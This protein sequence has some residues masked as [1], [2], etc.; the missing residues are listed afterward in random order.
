MRS[1]RRMSDIGRLAGHESHHHY[2]RF[3]PYDKCAKLDV[4]N[5]SVSNM[6]KEK[7]ALSQEKNAHFENMGKDQNSRGQFSGDE[8]IMAAHALVDLS[9]AKS[10][11]G[12]DVAGSRL[13]KLN[14][15]A[16][17]SPFPQSNNSRNMASGGC[18]EVGSRSHVLKS[19]QLFEEQYM[20]LLQE[21]N[22]KGKKKRGANERIDIK[23]AMILKKEGKWVN[24]TREVGEIPGVEIGDQFQYRAELA[25]VGLHTQL[26]AGIDYIK[27]GSKL[28]ATCIVDSGRY[29]NERRSPDVFIYTG[30]GGNPEIYKKKA[31]DQELK[32]GNLALKTSMLADLP[33]RVVRCHQSPEAPNP[34]GVNNGTGLR[35]TYL[36]LYKVSSCDRVRDKYGKLAFKFTMVRNQDRGGAS[37]SCKRERSHPKA[38]DSTRSKGKGGII[39][40][41]RGSYQKRASFPQA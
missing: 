18:P 23:A 3:Q 33:V 10:S 35:Y 34:L 20:K 32:R 14:S 7:N 2:K 28:F 27:I 5:G 30:E 19:I 38:N 24:T 21:Q 22:T 11:L 40:K 6:G 13:S 36:G 29:N 4:S 8:T 26:S 31:E 37:G 12:T 1:P 17:F 25:I 15:I 16:G 39:T 41:A 9:S